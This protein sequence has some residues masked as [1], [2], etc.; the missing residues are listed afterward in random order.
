MSNKE[1]QHLEEHGWVKVK[2]LT[3]ALAE[4]KAA[5]CRASECPTTSSFKNDNLHF[6]NQENLNKL[7]HET[8][9]VGNILKE[10]SLILRG[11][12]GDDLLYQDKPYLRISRPFKPQDNIGFHKDTM[13]GGYKEEYS[14]VIPLYSISENETL[15]VMS[16]SH[17]IPDEEFPFVQTQSTEVSKGDGRNKSGFLYAP[18]VM[19]KSKLNMTP[20]PLKL[21]EILIFSLATVHGQEENRGGTTRW[22]IDTRIVPANLGLDFSARPYKY[23][24]L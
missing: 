22:S 9:L 24:E 7:L 4:V 18:K 21:G 3:D 12:L 19:D 15:Q 16:G 20:V 5:I 8:D 1:K 6:D 10:N 23:V 11:L 14:C 17:K 13:Y 2:I